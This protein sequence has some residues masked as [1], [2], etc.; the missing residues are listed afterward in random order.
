MAGEGLDVFCR[1][2]LTPT[3]ASK[4]L[5]SVAARDPMIETLMPAVA[6]RLDTNARKC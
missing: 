2:Q 4:T 1:M 3:A 5:V 6:S